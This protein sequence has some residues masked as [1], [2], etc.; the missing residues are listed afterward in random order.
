MTNGEKT[1]RAPNQEFNPM[2]FY[3]GRELAQGRATSFVELE[4]TQEELEM[5]VLFCKWNGPQSSAQTKKK[6][7]PKQV[8]NYMKK[9]VSML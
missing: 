3:R 2:G 5:S 6:S 1:E 7:L 8:I 9:V 4:L